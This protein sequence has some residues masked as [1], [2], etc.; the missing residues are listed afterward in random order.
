M[1]LNMLVLSCL[2]LALTC[3]AETITV[4]DDGPADFDNIQDAIDYSW[5]GDTVEVRPG[6][7][8]ERVT[9]NGRKITLTS[10]NPDDDAIVNSTVIENTISS[11]TGTLGVVIFNFGE[12]ADSVITGFT[13]IG[14]GIYGNGNGISC[15]AS[16]PTITKNIIRDCDFS[17]IVGI[18]SASPIISNNRILDNGGTTGN[19]ESACG[20]RNCD[21]PIYNN[22]IHGNS[23]LDYNGG[24]IAYC[25][26]LI[27]NNVISQNRS[28]GSWGGGRGGGL[29]DCNGQIINNTIVGNQ[30]DD[31]GGGI[32]GYRGTATIK[33][34]IIANNTAEYG[35]GI[36]NGSSEYLFDNSYNCFWNNDTHFGGTATAGTGDFIRDPL[37]ASGS[38]YHLSST[39]GRW[40]NAGWVIDGV[41]SPCIDAG[42]PLDDIGLEPNPNGGRINIGAYGGTPK[43]SKS[44]SGIVEAICTNPPSMDTNNDCKID[45]TDFAEFAAQWLACGRDIQETC[46]E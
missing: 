43:A 11:S 29:S 30:A 39:V 44:S 19:S 18:Q 24:G 10:L 40:T 12:T 34:N 41:D 4:D 1:K 25:N 2:I 13:I 23:N 20:I 36:Y 42:A 7:Y 14:H 31:Y 16:S 9:F 5:D 45:W 37:F 46:W 27:Y 26:G 15:S 17:G 8:N 38:D 6:N 3:T 28:S 21:G 32:Y 33:N 22:I 35:G